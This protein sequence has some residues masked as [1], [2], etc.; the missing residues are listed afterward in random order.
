[1]A[2][3][4]RY[5]CKVMVDQR[6]RLRLLSLPAQLARHARR[7]LLHL[8]AHARWADLITDGVTRLRALTVPG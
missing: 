4:R 7:V 6:L 2:S 8:P 3:F 5:W 1:M